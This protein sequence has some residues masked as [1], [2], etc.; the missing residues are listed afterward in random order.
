MAPLK[1]DCDEKIKK[2]F[3]DALELQFAIEPDSRQTLS[4]YR[5]KEVYAKMSTRHPDYRDYYE[6][7]LELFKPDDPA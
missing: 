5:F 7:A 4:E 3:Q 2:L 1:D 6:K